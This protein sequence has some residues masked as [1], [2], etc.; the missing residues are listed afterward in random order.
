[1]ASSASYAAL[2][3]VEKDTLIQAFLEQHESDEWAEFTSALGT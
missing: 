2:S 3:G 1:M